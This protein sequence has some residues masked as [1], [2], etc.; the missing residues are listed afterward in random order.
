MKPL[1]ITEFCFNGANYFVDKIDI[2]DEPLQDEL[3][4]VFYNK[5][6][7]QLLLS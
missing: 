7:S 3:V 1:L 5:A 2:K 6:F 4:S